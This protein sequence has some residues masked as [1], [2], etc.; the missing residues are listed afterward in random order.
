MV[1]KGFNAGCH[2]LLIRLLAP[3]DYTTLNIPESRPSFSAGNILNYR[4]GARQDS[5]I[6]FDVQVASDSIDEPPEVFY[7]N[8]TPI[9]TAIVV[10]PRVTVTICDSK[11]F[12]ISYS[13]CVYVQQ[14]L[15]KSVSCPCMC[16]YGRMHACT[17][18]II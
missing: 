2:C 18:L 6:S 15:C 13:S 17:N 4:G 14:G 16:T 11:N 9:R 1:F 5:V 8:V 12:S 10:T 3:A 7:I